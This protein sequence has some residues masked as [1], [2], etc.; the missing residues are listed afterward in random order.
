MSC[1]N[2]YLHR[3]D[4]WEN[5]NTHTQIETHT[6]YDTLQF[7]TQLLTTNMRWR[8]GEDGKTSKRHVKGGDEAELEL[9]WLWQV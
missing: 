7:T 4:V 9:Q 6:L 5:T 3:K 8:G 1:C 2:E